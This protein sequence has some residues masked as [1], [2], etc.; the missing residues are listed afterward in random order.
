MAGEKRR[1]RTTQ[2]WI[3]SRAPPCRLSLHRPPSWPVSTHVDTWIFDLDNTLYAAGSAIWPAID[4]RITLYLA[5][6][7]GMDGL[8]ARALQKHY[9]Q[10]YGTTLRGLMEEHA[11][12]AGQF[13]EFVHDIDRTMLPPNPA[14]GQALL[15]LPGRKLIFT[16][17]SR[18]H[19]LKT[20]AQLGISDAFEDVF[21]IVAG[22]LLPKP[23]PQVYDRFLSKHRVDPTRAAMFED[24]ARNLEV[25]HA[26]GMRTVLV[27]PKLV[28]GDHREPW[29][30]LGSAEPLRRFH[31]RR[32]LG[33]LAQPRASATSF[34]Q[35]L[36][37]SASLPAGGTPRSLR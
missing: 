32:S 12:G 15:Q 9:Y 13:L 8:S 17:G 30:A 24:L 31:N 6:L 27:V 11:V 33:I 20:T 7:L 36:E 10:R 19:A 34:S 26:L 37:D 29:E 35:S 18:E 14:L 1:P 2:P 22:E 28:E 21:D 3:C 5:D 23:H 4:N 16:S 25:P